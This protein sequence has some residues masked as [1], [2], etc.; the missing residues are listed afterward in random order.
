MK[1][2]APM[3]QSADT[4]MNSESTH[5]STTQSPNANS[6][7][8][9]ADTHM[10]RNSTSQSSV[11][12]TLWEVAQTQTAKMHTTSITSSSISPTMALSDHPDSKQHLL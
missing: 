11:F 8:P 4:H 10:K 2:T 3:D 5:V 12:L 1:T 6:P 9:I 7:M